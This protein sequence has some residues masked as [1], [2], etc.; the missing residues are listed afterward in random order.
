[1]S[2]GLNLL[3]HKYEQLRSWLDN[4]E[5]MRGSESTVTVSQVKNMFDFL[6]GLE[7]KLDD[8]VIRAFEE[9]A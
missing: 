5:R 9:V 4:M 7:I 3:D 8:I 2:E 1:M 6:D